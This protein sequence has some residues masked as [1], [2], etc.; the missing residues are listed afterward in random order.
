MEAIKYQDP[1]WGPLCVEI[2]SLAEIEEEEV[3]EESHTT[4]IG[5]IFLT[6][7]IGGEDIKITIQEEAL[8]INKIREYIQSERISLLK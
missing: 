6:E 8:L 1:L 5:Q 7:V 2:D 4:V 3:E